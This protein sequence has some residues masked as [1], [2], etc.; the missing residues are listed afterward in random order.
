MRSVFVAGWCLLIVVAPRVV[1][2]Q[3]DP[4]SL[5]VT[6][7]P[8]KTAEAAGHSIPANSPRK[9]EPSVFQ[10][11][12][13][14]FFEVLVLGYPG[15]IGTDSYLGLRTGR[16]WFYVE[17]FYTKRQRQT[18]EQVRCTTLKSPSPNVDTLRCTV[19]LASSTPLSRG[20]DSAVETIKEELAFF[21]AVGQS[22]V[23]ACTQPITVAEQREELDC[24]KQRTLKVDWQ[25]GANWNEGG[26]TVSEVAAHHLGL[27]DAT[28]ALVGKH[29]VRLPD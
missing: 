25:L 9:P 11:Q 4:F 6:K 5:R 17:T 24:K 2:S 28:R 13:G 1:A 19:S 15:G 18:A 27:G 22:G 23:P 21:C 3:A 26:I 20:C 10:A 7:G 12:T 29:A 8:Y 14:G 16:G